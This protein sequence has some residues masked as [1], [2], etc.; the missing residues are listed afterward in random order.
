M[1]SGTEPSGSFEELLDL[2]DELN[3]PDGYKA[4]II[5]GSIV[6]SPWSKGYYVRVM[7]SVCSQ[8]EP[9]LPEGHVIERAPVLFVFPGVDR[10]LDAVRHRLRVA[11]HPAVR[12][13]PP[14]PEV[15]RLHPRHHRLPG[16]R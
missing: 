10:V 12:R 4:E 16:P 5:R 2:L 13:A 14:H 3:V 6:V 7:R 9:Y 15:V 1:I 8:L 11:L